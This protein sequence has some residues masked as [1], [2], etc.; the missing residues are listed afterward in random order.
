VIATELRGL[1][2]VLLSVWELNLNIVISSD[3]LDSGTFGAHDRSMELLGYSTFHCHL[4]FLKREHKEKRAKVKFLKSNTF[5]TPS[6][7]SSTAS[8][9]R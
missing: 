6:S 2:W 8:F 1:T 7:P 3:L 4:S 9:R 5:P